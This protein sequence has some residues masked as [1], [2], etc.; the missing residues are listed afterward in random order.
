MNTTNNNARHEHSHSDYVRTQGNFADTTNDDVIITAFGASSG[1]VVR[2][3]SSGSYQLYNNETPVFSNTAIESLLDS[4]APNA[5]ILL[6][7]VHYNY[8]QVLRLPWLLLFVPDP[9]IMRAYTMMPLA[10]AQPD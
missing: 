8:H 9:F 6:V 2:F 3:P 7:E 5:G 10:A 4:G 1:N